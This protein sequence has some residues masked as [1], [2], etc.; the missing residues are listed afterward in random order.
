M[1]HQAEN[2]FKAA[3]ICTLNMLISP[4][5]SKIIPYVKYS[6]PSDVG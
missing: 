6:Q 1:C 3:V 2:V 4:A 5:P